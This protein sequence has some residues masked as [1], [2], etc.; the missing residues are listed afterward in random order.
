MKSGKSTLEFE[1][2]DKFTT[3]FK[4]ILGNEKGAQV[5]SFDEKK[6]EVLNLMLLSF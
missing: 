3:D 5:D 2:L 1:Y 4:D 6:I